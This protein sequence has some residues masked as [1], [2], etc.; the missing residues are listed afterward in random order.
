MWV[1]LLI[2]VNYLAIFEIV[3]LPLVIFKSVI[4]Y[5][6]LL[7][8]FPTSILITSYIPDARIFKIKNT[9][10][11]YIIAKALNMSYSFTV[12]SISSTLSNIS[13]VIPISPNGIGIFDLYFEYMDFSLRGYLSILEIRFLVDNGK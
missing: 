1:L 10:L 6:L 13:S 11:I 2:I 9:Y 3:L 7:Y 4:A 5:R 12:I 8:F